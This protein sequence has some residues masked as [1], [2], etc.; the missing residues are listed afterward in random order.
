MDI[1]FY[2]GQNGAGKSTAL[3][4][5][6]HKNFNSLYVNEEGL[7]TFSIKKPR[8]KIDIENKMYHY[9][10]DLERGNNTQNKLSSE[11]IDE[12]YILLL[13]E[14]ITLK[15]KNDLFKDNMS[16]GQEKFSNLLSIFTEYNFNNL[17]YICLDEPENFLD[18]DYI[19]IIARLILKLC[20]AG[21]KVR[22]ATHNV[23]LLTECR[24]S[25]EKIIVLKRGTKESVEYRVDINKIEQLMRNVSKDVLAF[26]DRSYQI[27][28]KMKTKLKSYEKPSLFKALISQTIENEDFYKCLFNKVVILVEGDSE[29]VALKS[30]KHR[31]E[32]SV[33]FF[34]PHGKVY[35]PF[36]T[37]LFSELGKD[38][39]VVIDDD[40]SEN[41]TLPKMLTSYF[42]KEKSEGQLKLLVHSPDFE[43][44]YDVPW[45]AIA[46][47]V[48]LQNGRLTGEL[49]PIVA[50]IYFDNEKNRDRLY[51]SFLEIIEATDSVYEFS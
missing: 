19:K 9:I 16:K 44:H 15:S 37:K 14:A 7:P 36:F 42:E 33:E 49:K 10:N 24:A 48:G 20:E 6:A 26:E 13:Q 46:N 43:K 22:I 28:E 51:N 45:E 32:S 47:E 2:V 18:E 34:T 27:N 41:E 8:V 38:V 12:R 39:I 25:I 4:K 29:I 30:I 1:E 23:R 11:L 40:F 31:F 5:I 3:R 21:L 35:L 50:M 17:D